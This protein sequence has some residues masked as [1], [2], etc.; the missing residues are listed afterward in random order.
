M[1]LEITFLVNTLLQIVGSFFLVYLL[2]YIAVKTPLFGEIKEFYRSV[3]FMGCLLLFLDLVGLTPEESRNILPK[4]L[5]LV[6]IFLS[7]QLRFNKK[8]RQKRIAKG[9]CGW[10]F[11]PIAPMMYDC[12]HCHQK[13]DLPS[14]S[15]AQK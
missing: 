1:K 11:K 2:E 12:P 8:V 15:E 10:C 5:A 7:Y 14:P 13:Y 4:I 9:I 3:F 6:V